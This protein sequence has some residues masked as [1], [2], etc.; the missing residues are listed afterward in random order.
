MNQLFI[1]GVEMQFEKLDELGDPLDQINE[2]IDWEIFRKPIE[3]AIR[4]ADYSKG[5]CPPWDVVL[6]FKIVMLMAW[7]N[8][9]Y[10]QTQYQI[11]NRL[12][13]MRFLNVTAGSK[14][15]ADSTI[16]DFKEALKK[17][18]LDTVLFNLFNDKLLDYGYKLNSGTMI[19]ASFVEVPRRRVITEK[20]L[21]NPADEL[22]KNDKIN[23]KI[24]ETETDISIIA[25][26]EKTEHILAQTDLDARYTKKNDETFFG[27][28]DH[29]AIDKDTKFIVGYDVT[30]AEVHD[31]QIFL[32]FITAQT[33][34]VWADSAY[35][36][37][38]HIEILKDLNPDIKINICH[39]AYRNK[40]LTK[41]QKEENRI[42]SKVRARVEHVFG[43]MTKSMGGMFA[44]CIGIERVRRDIG[45]KNLA[46]NIKRLAF[47]AG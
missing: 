10:K 6:M 7:Y 46:Y 2:I 34:A 37:A 30:S 41:A 45:L 9:S 11:N 39:R 31:S 8:M 47:L 43:I 17:H 4:R 1:N 29:A 5:G 44:R 12:D 38:I 13:F 24:E 26:D 40:P 15:P 21:K 25:N 42:I 18:E 32:Q 27:Y 28:K 3:K 35:M 14:L 22:P 23:V 16:W 33:P 19:D 20:E 36:S